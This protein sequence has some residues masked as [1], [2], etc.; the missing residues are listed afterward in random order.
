MVSLRFKI[1]FDNKFSV[2]IFRSIDVL[3][4]FIFF[5][6]FKIILTVRIEAFLIANFKINTCIYDFRGLMHTFI[7]SAAYQL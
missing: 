6:W 5:I 4:V 3:N 1:Y 2:L 7:L